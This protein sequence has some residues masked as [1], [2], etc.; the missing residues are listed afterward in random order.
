MWNS[1]RQEYSMARRL[2]G[3]LSQAAL[4]DGLRFMVIHLLDKFYKYTVQEKFNILSTHRVC[5]LRQEIY[6][7]TTTT[8][9]YN[10]VK[11][12]LGPSLFRVVP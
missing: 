5:K 1:I 10:V 7:I 8:L 3:V 11:Q 6:Q 9:L 4:L 12:C 2:T